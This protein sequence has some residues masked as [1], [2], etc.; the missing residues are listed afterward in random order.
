MKA[1]RTVSAVLL[2]LSLLLTLTG[3]NSATISAHR[4]S[5]DPDSHDNYG[6]AYPVTY[7]FSI[8]VSLSSAK[9]Y[10]RS[11]LAWSQLP[12]KTSSDFFNGIEA[13]RFDFKNHCAYI[14]ASF[15]STRDF[16]H[17][18]VTDDSGNVQ[19]IT[20]LETC[21][22][23]DNRRCVVAGNA[24]LDACFDSKVKNPRPPLTSGRRNAPAPGCPTPP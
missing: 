16:F 4:V 18:C 11:G 13:V 5:V 1:V 8:P 15:D 2:T 7:K 21:E 17:L 3:C 10:K 23:Y 12:T 6:L 20:F 22:Y 14:S 9:A 24:D 19:E